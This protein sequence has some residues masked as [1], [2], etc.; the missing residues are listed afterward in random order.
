M[1]NL[2]NE[3]GSDAI[4]SAQMLISTLIGKQGHIQTCFSNATPI[5][6]ITTDQVGKTTLLR[7]TSPFVLYSNEKKQR[8][9]SWQQWFKSRLFVS[10]LWLTAAANVFFIDLVVTNNSYR[11]SNSALYACI[12]TLFLTPALM[13]CGFLFKTSASRVLSRLSLILLTATEFFVLI[14]CISLSTSNWSAWVSTPLL[15]VASLLVL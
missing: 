10:I 6:K 15:L 14:D 5:P 7:D 4:E 9:I 13:L 12:G 1:R 8:W 11:L 2:T 3:S